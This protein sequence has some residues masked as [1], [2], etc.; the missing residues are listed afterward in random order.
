MK[1]KITVTLEN[2]DKLKSAI[3][4]AENKLAEFRE[5][6]KELEKI[7]LEVQIG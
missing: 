7:S 5:A 3:I 4:K 1:S 6:V 2:V